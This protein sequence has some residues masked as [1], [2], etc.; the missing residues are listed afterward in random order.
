MDAK[1]VDVGVEDETEAAPAR[2]PTARVAFRTNMTGPIDE[3]INVEVY[4][5]SGKK[6]ERPRR[7]LDGP[8]RVKV[9][10]YQN[11]EFGS[12]PACLSR[13]AIDMDE[14]RFD[15]RLSVQ[16]AALDRRLTNSKANSAFEALSYVIDEPQCTKTFFDVIMRFSVPAKLRAHRR[17]PIE[18]AIGDRPRLA[19]DAF[20]V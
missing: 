19:P 20:G 10:A 17:S 8:R 11:A 5:E 18:R 9:G 4:Q 14:L 13:L 1:S 2:R 16:A 7:V 15:E 6:Y 12:F 3:W